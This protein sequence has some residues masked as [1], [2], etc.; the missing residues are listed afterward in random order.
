MSETELHLRLRRSSG[1]SEIKEEYVKMHR[2]RIVFTFVAYKYETGWMRTHEMQVSELLNG[3][4]EKS[5]QTISENAILFAIDLPLCPYIRKLANVFAFLPLVNSQ[6]TF[7]FVWLVWLLVFCYIIF[8]LYQFHASIRISHYRLPIVDT[9]E[10]GRHIEF[11]SL[12]W[13]NL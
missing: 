13:T 11:L 3:S 10:I 8:F 5:K 4:N 6:I 7:C 1:Y 2:I 12:K 9:A